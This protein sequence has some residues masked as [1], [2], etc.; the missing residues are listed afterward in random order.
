MERE[1]ILSIL[2]Q[3]QRNL[4]SYSVRHLSMLGPI[5]KDEMHPD[6]CVDLFVEFEHTVGRYVYFDLQNYLEDLLGCQV[7]LGSVR[8]LEP[9]MKE[10]VLEEAIPVA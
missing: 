8:S 2:H 5:V 9:E 3:H 1:T 4:H 10:E 6:G 7:D